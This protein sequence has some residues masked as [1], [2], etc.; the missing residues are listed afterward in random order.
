MQ[1]DKPKRHRRTEEEML[2]DLETKL[3]QLREKA[4]ARK[5]REGPM[6]KA[7][8]KLVKSVRK[9][10]EQAQSEGRTDL[11]LSAQAFAAGLERAAAQPPV[12]ERSRRERGD[13]QDSEQS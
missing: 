1:Q 7:T 13:E 3:A 2:R 9:Y 6:V 12:K 10:A 8:K 5:Q 4:E 11:A